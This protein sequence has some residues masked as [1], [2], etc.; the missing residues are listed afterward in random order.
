MRK[1]TRE[2]FFVSFGAMIEND[3]KTL[4]GYST[5]A[6]EFF[7][8]VT[9]SDL[10]EIL[11]GPWPSPPG[12]IYTPGSTRSDPPTL[13]ESKAFPAGLFSSDRLLINSQGQVVWEKSG[14]VVTAQ[15][16]QEQQ[17][18]AAFVLH[19]DAVGQPLVVRVSEAALPSLAVQSALDLRSAPSVLLELHAAGLVELPEFEG[20]AQGGFQLAGEAA[21]PAGPGFFHLAEV[22]QQVAKACTHGLLCLSPPEYRSV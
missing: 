13:M 1:V 4:G 16:Q 9:E 6:V 2:E 10:Q 19:A 20:L 21:C 22:F 15:I 11:Y 14:E 17:K 3:R 5:N 12:I 7:G 8:S 18:P